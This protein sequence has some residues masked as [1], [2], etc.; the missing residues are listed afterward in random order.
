MKNLE[1]IRQRIAKACRTSNR[2]PD[3][4]RLIAVGKG[5]PVEKLEALRQSGQISFG[6]N[7]GQELAAKAE[8]LRNTGIEWHFLGHLQT[9]KINRLLPHIAWLH[10]LDSLQLAEE[11]DK[12]AARKLNV[13][14]EICFGN[15]PSKTGL[16]AEEALQLLPELNRFQNLEVRGFMT[17]PPQ[18]T[19]PEETRPYFC[20][21]F[22]LLKESNSGYLYR[23]PLT[24]LSMGM[25][26]DFEIAIAEGAT[27]VRIGRSLFGE[28]KV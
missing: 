25:S 13:L 4:V 3:L 23:F 2:S 5:Q 15:E 19:S 12:R 8:A 18:T 27:M 21:L 28:R 7:Y 17:I 16:S 24:E 11:L 10:S 14:L 26:G 6:E 9:N 22:E 1:A 20:Q